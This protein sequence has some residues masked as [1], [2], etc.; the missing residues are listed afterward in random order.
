[1]SSPEPGGYFQAGQRKDEPFTA[2]DIAEAIKKALRPPPP[3][4][5]GEYIKYLTTPERYDWLVEKG[6]I[7]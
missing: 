1:M 5:R 4:R 7:I 2:E 6:F 3:L